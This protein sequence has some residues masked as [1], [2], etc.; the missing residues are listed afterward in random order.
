MTD[1]QRYILILDKANELM[2]DPGNQPKTDF[3]I[4]KRLFNNA[5]AALVK[6]GVPAG[7]SEDG[8]SVTISVEGK[9]FT[10]MTKSIEQVLLGDY[11]DSMDTCLAMKPKYDYSAATASDRLFGENLKS[12]DISDFDFVLPEICYT[13]ASPNDTR[14][15]DAQVIPEVLAG[16]KPE[17]RPQDAAI[18]TSLVH[19]SGVPV[20]PVFEIN[21]D[22]EET[23]L[24]DD[25]LPEDMEDDVATVSPIAARPSVISTVECG[26]TADLEQSL[27]NEFGE[28]GFSET[29]EENNNN[30]IRLFRPS[31]SDEPSEPESLPEGLEADTEDEPFVDDAVSLSTPKLRLVEVAEEE[32]YHLNSVRETASVGSV[33]A[34][35]RN[36]LGGSPDIDISN[37]KF[38]PKNQSHE[39]APVRN[40]VSTSLP[41]K[42]KHSGGLFGLFRKKPENTPASSGRESDSAPEKFAPKG[43][44]ADYSFIPN[45]AYQNSG[46]K[47]GPRKEVYND[48]PR[49]SAEEK[50]IVDYSHDGGELFQHIKNVALKKKLGNDMIGPFRFIFWP[51]ALP[52]TSDQTFAE[53]IV[54]VVDS[55]NHFEGAYICDRSTPEIRIALGPMDFKVYGLWEAGEFES[56]VSVTGKTASI[57]DVQEKTE[58]ILPSEIND[59]YFDQFRLEK[60]GQPKLMI[61]PFKAQNRGEINIP[62]TGYVELNGKK[63][64]L[65][66]M[67]GNT[68]KYKYNGRVVTITGH[69]EHGRF[70]YLAD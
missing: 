57:F 62:I 42:E 70:L 53:M 54:Y 1:K 19:K 30:V 41:A 35:D 58:V 34:V 27:D 8:S 24:V 14:P 16:E 59:F 10:S 6:T 9:E 21:S 31:V 32:E 65:Q 39:S 11:R 17:P 3:L 38:K 60:K 51:T 67:S 52:K 69:F 33:S 26:D 40:A 66:R 12:I 48:E 18:E 20:K 56:H 13:N 64:P 47:N 5:F 37:S 50:E 43:A 4:N 63:I 22:P 29:P 36:E 46:I 45:A 2:K 55:L 25:G 15:Q 7:I 23:S 49:L 28:E 61:V 44:S 68:L